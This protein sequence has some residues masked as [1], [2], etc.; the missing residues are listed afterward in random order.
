LHQRIL[1]VGGYGTFG[2]RLAL[3]L[4]DEPRLTLII[5]GRSRDKAVAF[6]AR[7][8]AGA[9][10]IAAAFDRDGNLDP[11]LR[12]VAPDLVVD[13]TGPFQAYGESPYHL[14][15]ACLALGIDYL[16][17]ADGSAFVEGIGRFDTAA[18]A[19]DIFILSGVSSFPVLTAAVVRALAPDLARIDTITAG[20]APLPHANVGLNVIRAI[21]GYA[22]KPVQLVRDGRPAVGCR[23]CGFRWWTCP[24]CSCCRRSG[25]VSTQSGL[26]PAPCRTSC[27]DC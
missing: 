21:A 27:I 18:R 3:L 6:C 25:R 16:D 20:I 14:V 17:L 8:P 5:A 1:I 22:G 24:I 15:E 7:L 12:A 13:A 10:R 19:R 4:A 26:A 2:G 11:Q 23:A 9:E